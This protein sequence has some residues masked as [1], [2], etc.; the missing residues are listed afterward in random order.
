MQNL[1]LEGSLQTLFESTCS[2]Y[3]FYAEKARVLKEQIEQFS[4]D[5]EANFSQIGNYFILMAHTKSIISFLK[6]KLFNLISFANDSEIKLSFS[7]DDEFV[8]W[9]FSCYYSN[10]IYFETCRN[11]IDLENC[12]LHKDFIHAYTANSDD[13]DAYKWFLQFAK[14]R[15]Y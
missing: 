8:I 9:I 7:V 11:V 14:S 6:E 3:K 5:K 15:K 13:M 2:T 1:L 4:H 10:P 12:K